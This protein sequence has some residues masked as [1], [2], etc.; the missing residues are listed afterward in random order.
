MSARKRRIKRKIAML[1]RIIETCALNRNRNMSRNL[2]SKT[3]AE[4]QEPMWRI[5]ATAQALGKG[6]VIH[7]VKDRSMEAIRASKLASS[8][9]RK[10][11]P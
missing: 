2:F 7:R 3:L 1:V 9:L 6:R 11:A 4:K 5:F 10:E 8:V